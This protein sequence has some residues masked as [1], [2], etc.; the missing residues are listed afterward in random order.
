MAD[1]GTGEQCP[2]PPETI[3]VD[4]DILEEAPYVAVVYFLNILVRYH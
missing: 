3:L 4:L 2:K 1:G